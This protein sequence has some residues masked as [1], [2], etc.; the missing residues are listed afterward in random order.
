[1]QFHMQAIIGACAVCV[2]AIAVQHAGMFV[3][4]GAVLLVAV[5]MVAALMKL[6]FMAEQLQQAVQQGVQA[7]KTMQP[8]VQHYVLKQQRVLD[9]VKVT[10]H[11]MQDSLLVGNAQTQQFM[12]MVEPQLKEMNVSCAGS[13]LKCTFI[14]SRL[15]KM[16]QDGRETARHL[17][18]IVVEYN[19]EM[20]RWGLQW[21]LRRTIEERATWATARSRL[22]E[23]CNEKA[24]SLIVQH[25][26]QMVKAEAMDLKQHAENE[27]TPADRQVQQ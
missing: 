8:S 17:M 5:L 3:Q 9:E 19:G 2:L 6:L 26:V 12:E 15:E 23:L 22:G 13:Y 25:A 27:W 21:P 10:L 24:W 18:Q 4:N 16:M 7:W 20:C 1:M 11:M 14:E